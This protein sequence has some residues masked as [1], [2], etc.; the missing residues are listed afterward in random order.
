MLCQWI[1]TGEKAG[2]LGKTF[3]NVSAFYEKNVQDK[4]NTIMSLVQPVSIVVIGL[5]VGYIAVCSTQS[6]MVE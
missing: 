5:L 2:R 3:E 1:A 4:I 6:S